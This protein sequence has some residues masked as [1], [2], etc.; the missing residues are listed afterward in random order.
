MHYLKLYFFSL[1]LFCEPT[2]ASATALDSTT[3]QAASKEQAQAEIFWPPMSPSSLKAILKGEIVVDSQVDSRKTE[4]GDFQSLDFKAIALHPSS[5]Q[6]AMV[7]LGRYEMYTEWLE[8]LIEEASYDE[9]KEVLNLVVTHSLLP[10]KMRV[11]FNIPRIRKEGTYPFSFDRGFL[12]GL[13]GKFQLKQEQGDNNRPG[14]CLF[15]ITAFRDG[16][17]SKLGNGVLELFSI[18]I[19][20]IAIDKLFRLSSL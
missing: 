3:N 13:S 8:G 16:P 2:F 18:T 11:L 9:Q 15:Y 14:R 1:L 19:T 12:K 5:C 6:K 20:R 4:A 7:K 17:D 10:F